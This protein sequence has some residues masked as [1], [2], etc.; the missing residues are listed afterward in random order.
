MKGQ[1]MMPKLEDAFELTAREAWNR[2]SLEERSTF[3]RGPYQLSVALERRDGSESKR[4]VVKYALADECG[5]QILSEREQELVVDDCPRQFGG[6]E[7][8]LRCPSCS[9]RCRVLFMHPSA[10]RFSCRECSALS[11]GKRE[12]R[13]KRGRVRLDS[14]EIEELL[15]NWKRPAPDPLTNL[16]QALLACP[17]EVGATG[18]RAI[19]PFIISKYQAFLADQARLA[20]RDQS[21]LDATLR[22]YREILKRLESDSAA[23]DGC[24]Q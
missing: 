22:R 5:S 9:R 2:S 10:T 1:R 24:P 3:K 20:E 21:E 4:V 12:R 19:E 14:S 18:Y 16:I 11:H 8:L 15:V 13:R 7:P 17:P 23:S 6:S